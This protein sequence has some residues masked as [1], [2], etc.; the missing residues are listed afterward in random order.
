MDE[1]EISSQEKEDAEAFSCCFEDTSALASLVYSCAFV[2]KSRAAGVQGGYDSG[3]GC[4]R[5]ALE[6]RC[7][8]ARTVHLVAAPVYCIATCVRILAEG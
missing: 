8:A 6:M 3:T 5:F 1:G 4:H 2:S 7:L